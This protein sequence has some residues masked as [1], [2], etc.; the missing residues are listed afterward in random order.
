MS[1]ISNIK[2]QDKFSE[3]RCPFQKKFCFV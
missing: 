2:I 1:L 3:F